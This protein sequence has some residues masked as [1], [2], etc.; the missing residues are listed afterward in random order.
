MNHHSVACTWPDKSLGENELK[1]DVN[2]PKRLGQELVGMQQGCVL[3][4]WEK[5]WATMN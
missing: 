5:S 3:T 4:T 1:G 2:P